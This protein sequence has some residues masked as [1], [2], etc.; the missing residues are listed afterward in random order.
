M[1]MLKIISYIADG[2]CTVKNAILKKFI[3]VLVVALAIS[4][5]AAYFT[6]KIVL[7]DNTRTDM[8]ETLE[9]V[10]YA[11]DYSGNLQQQV[12]QM[13]ESSSK[14]DGR[15][16][17]ISKD[18]KVYADSSVSDPDRMDNHLEREEIVEALN[19]ELSYSERYSKTLNTL[20]LYVAIPSKNN[21]Y[22]I[23]LALPFSGLDKYLQNLIPSI[24]LGLALALLISAVLAEQFAKSISRPLKEISDDMR[25]FKD[26]KPEFHFPECKYDELSII[27]SA[28][29]DMAS[30]VR[31][32][33]EKLEF[34]RRIRQEFF[35]NA[36]HELKTPITSIKGYTEL[37]QNGFAVDE[38][39]QK[40]F[41][42][43]IKKETDNMTNLINDILM[44]SQLETKE[45]KAAI[46]EVRIYLIVQDVIDALAPLAKEMEVTI[47]ADCSPLTIEANPQQMQQLISNLVSNAIKYNKP[48]GCVWIRIYSEGDFLVLEVE[49]NGVGIPE[50]SQ[51]RIF[52]RFYRVDKGRSKK[53][54]GTGLGLSIVKHIVQYCGGSIQMNST[55]NFG[56]KFTVHL[57]LKM[58][59]K[60]ESSQA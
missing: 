59:P 47:E 49:D 50:E 35:S 28:T 56:T 54:G 38:T 4:G 58:V 31:D 7:M 2:S 10:D 3:L 32:Y 44:I 48:N 43:R 18:G 24:L 22:I 8:L 55:P 9:L 26:N 40:D 46:S 34:E 51:S 33:V 13:K 23:R 16:T 25:N 12:E 29:S 11:L 39:M 30:N 6:L 52:E 27:A 1:V 21:D 37:L 20:M 19:G 60:E 42:N 17:I 41:L 57:P 14:L 5:G 15:V 53:N 36:S 45:A